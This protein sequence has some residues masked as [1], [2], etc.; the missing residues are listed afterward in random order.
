MLMNIE[1]SDL[2]QVGVMSIFYLTV[3]F[4]L[5]PLEDS[6]LTQVTYCC[7]VTL[8]CVHRYSLC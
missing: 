2:T 6:L 5:F 1:T 8:L 3:L 4:L 7:L